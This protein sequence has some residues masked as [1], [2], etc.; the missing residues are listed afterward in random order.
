MYAIFSDGEHQYRAEEGQ[1]VE[2]QLK[3]L[4]EGS[5]TI[6]FDRV[7]LIGDLED[8]AKVGQPTVEGAKV[9]ATVVREAKGDKITIQKQRRRKH[10]RRK[11][12]HRQKFLHVKVDK[13]EY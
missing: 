13:I 2:V 7:L 1:L 10:Y 11:L 5:T 8:G 3:V 4:P 9:V 12:G 6:E